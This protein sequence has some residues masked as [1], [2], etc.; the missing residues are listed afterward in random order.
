MAR[1]PAAEPLE[2]L[3]SANREEELPVVVIG[4]GP[5]GL[6]AAA[7]L[8]ERRLPVVVLEAG[9]AVGAAMREWGHIRTFTPWEYIVDPTAEKLLASVGWVRPAGRQSPTGTEIGAVMTGRLGVMLTVTVVEAEFVETQPLAAVTV[10]L[11]VVVEAGFAFGV[12]LDAF[13]SPVEGDHW[14]ETP[15]EPVS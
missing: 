10:R 13:D 15:P 5:V 11:Y 2:V 14:H 4:A 12:Q 7:H 1:T 8:L 3:T 6:A 9:E